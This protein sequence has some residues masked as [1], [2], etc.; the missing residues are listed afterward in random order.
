MQPQRP[1][2]KAPALRQAAGQPGRSTAA[3]PFDVSAELGAHSGEDL[4]GKG[5]LFAR[6]EAGE[7]GGGEDFGGNGLLDGGFDGP[8]AFAGVLDE[9]GVVGKRWIFDQRH[10]GEV[11][12]PGTD[13]AAT[14]PELG[15]IG[16]VEFEAFVFGE[17]F[18]I[19]V[20]HEVEAFGVGLHDAILDAVVDHFD[21]V[22]GAGRAAVQIAFFGGAAEFFASGSARD[23]PAAGSESFED[24]LDGGEG[25]IGSADHE[26]VAALDAPDAAAGAGIHIM[27]AS[28]FEL[29]GAADIVLIEAVAAVNDDVVGFH[30]GGE[31][32]DGSFGRLTGGHHDPY[33]AGLGQFLDQLFKR[34][35]AFGALGFE[36]LDVDGIE[37]EDSTFVTAALQPPHHVGAH[38]PQTDQADMHLVSSR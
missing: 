5:V 3:G 22:A 14:A 34:A 23:V 33:G 7:E 38:A 32:L 35:G 20:D 13:D 24:V 37:V 25:L 8:A 26:A 28:R 2:Y 29:G 4:F 10:G 27:N 15:N 17:V 21:E 16:D 11:E 12:Q 6:A 19:L 9:T 18:G 1:E 30:G 36:V 31:R